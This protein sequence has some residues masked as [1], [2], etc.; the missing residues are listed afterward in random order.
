M[1]TTGKLDGK[2]AFITG[3]A[4]GQGRSHALR[5]AGEGADIIAV[6]ICEDY[7]TTAYP[8]ATEEDLEQTAKEVR[9]LGRRVVTRKADVRDR[10]QLEAA[11][12]GG[13]AELGRLDIVVANAGICVLGAW[14]EVTP[15]VWQDTLDTN[16]TGAWN[17]ITVAVPHLVRAGGGSV[18][19]TGSTCGVKGNPFFAP[20]VAAKHGL[21][22]VARTLANE[23]AQHHIR[24]NVVHPAGVVT[25]LTHGLARI[26]ELI[27]TNPRLGGAFV[28][29]L[30]VERLEPG[31]VSN[32]VLFLASD[33]AKFMT[34][35][36]LV[37]DAGNTIF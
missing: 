26:G 10:G 2:V 13:V 11:L 1:S 31:D 18:I 12:T 35:A 8:M 30:P 36:E 5:L 25:E 22:G 24:V 14:D 16:L 6:D 7:E 20:Y 33:D 19:A 27:E 28:N 4:R 29:A 17:T 21:V 23:L 3:G 32:A 37:V 9:A 15:R 34:G